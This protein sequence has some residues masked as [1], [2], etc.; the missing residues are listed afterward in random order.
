MSDL[1]DRLRA[2]YCNCIPAYKDR[3]LMDPQCE[4]CQTLPER[5]EAADEIDKLLILRDSYKADLLAMRR[6]RDALREQLTLAE[7]VRTSQVAGLVEGAEKL[8][9]RVAE[10]EQDAARYRWLR[11][12]HNQDCH[13]VGKCAP[14]VETYEAIDWLYDDALDESIDAA[15]AALKGASYE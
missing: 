14:D 5:V 2:E 8:R 7:S 13:S 1:T 6:E 10:L 3:G 15:R 11:D 4:S 12:P 9:E